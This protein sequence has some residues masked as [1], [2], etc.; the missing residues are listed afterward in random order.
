MNDREICEQIVSDKTCNLDKSQFD[1]DCPCN[2]CPL[3]KYYDC[4]YS[5]PYEQA[6]LWLKDHTEGK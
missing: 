1:G 3:I 2:H 5:T 6:K 4:L